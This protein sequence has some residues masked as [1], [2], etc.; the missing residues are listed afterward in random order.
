MSGQASESLPYIVPGTTRRQGPLTQVRARQHAITHARVARHV[1]PDLRPGLVMD[2]VPVSPAEATLRNRANPKA[3]AQQMWHWSADQHRL[4][5]Q[6]CGNAPLTPVTSRTASPAAGQT[7]GAG[8][9]Y[10]SFAADRHRSLVSGR[11]RIA[12][13]VNVRVELFGRAATQSGVRDV[14]VEVPTGATLRDVALALVE[15]FPVLDWI[16]EICRPARNLEYGRW[17]DPV[18]EGDEVSFIPPVSGG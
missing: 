1:G 3:N 16:P 2:T 12:A 13:T 9:C 14:Q 18:S 10:T 5:L 4:N 11:G 17:A 6:G 15:Q 7:F 8:R